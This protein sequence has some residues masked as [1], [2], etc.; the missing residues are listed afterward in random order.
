MKRARSLVVGIP[1]DFL[2]LAGFPE[3]TLEQIE[4]FLAEYAGGD[5]AA[6]IERG[7]GI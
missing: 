7:I 1:F 2:S 5:I 3:E 6:M 4:A